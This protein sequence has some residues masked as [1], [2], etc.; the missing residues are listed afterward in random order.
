MN[1]LPVT[2]FAPT[3][4]ISAERLRLI[5]RMGE[6][7]IA[8]T[9]VWRAQKSMFGSGI[10]G[11]DAGLVPVLFTLEAGEARISELADNV[12]SDVSTVSRQVSSLVSA[13]FATKLADAED[14][15]VMKVSL[16]D[17]GHDAV[18]A[19]REARGEWLRHHL[20]DWS[21]DDISTLISYFDRLVSTGRTLL[22]EQSHVAP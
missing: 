14:R 7:M 19:L 1:S 20:N 10:P 11:L 9:R 21:D 4:D 3:S 22:G 17:A 16:T 13:G 15:R 6:S 12:C 8:L 18:T 5:E 2:N